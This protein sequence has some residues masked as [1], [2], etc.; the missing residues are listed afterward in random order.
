MLA[1][2]PGMGA[3]PAHAVACVNCHRRSGQGGVEGGILVPS[4]AQ[5]V[6]MAPG[7]P[8][9]SALRVPMQG[10]RHHQRSAYSEAALRRALAHGRDPD[11][12]ELGPAMP[13]YALGEQAAADLLAYLRTR[14]SQPERGVSATALYLATVVTPQA[15]PA[16]R[17]AVLSAMRAWTNTLGLGARRASWRVWELQG[18]PATWGQQLFAF[19]QAQPVYALISG[20]G[21]QEW[22]PVDAFCEAQELPCIFPSVDHTPQREERYWN[23]YLSGGIEAEARMLAQHLL[24]TEAGQR[25]QRVVP[26]ADSQG[27]LAAAQRLRSAMAA[28]GA[29]VVAATQSPEHAQ[30]PQPGDMVVL[31]LDSAGAQRWL[32]RHPPAS[33]PASAPTPQLHSVVLSAQLAP[34]A[35]TA[36]EPAWRPWVRWVSQQS[37]PGRLGAA[38]A[39]SLRPWMRQLGLPEDLDAQALGDAHAA[40]YFFSDA[41]ALARGRLQPDHLLERLEQAV[42]GR[43]PG[44]T[45]FQLS[46]GPGQRVAA[47]GGFM[48]AYVA[49]AYEVLAPLPGHLRT[50]E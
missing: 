45:Y 37:D 41:L 49:P 10:L 38:N 33:T 34:Y 43:P 42:D 40:A 23:A 9:V 26:V 8:P 20:A 31:W 5:D 15:S 32:Q 25:P 1:T 30:P 17:L 7:Q 13:R 4:I 16:R 29:V 14:R 44:A 35:Q 47:K 22:A 6:L 21:G 27:G 12:Q 11:G 18:E 24:G 3:L 28:N 48:L 19:W 36:I 50:H 2:R 39:L 46:L